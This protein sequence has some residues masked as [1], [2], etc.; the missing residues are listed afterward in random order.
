MRRRKDHRCRTAA[1]TER[2]GS[3]FSTGGTPFGGGGGVAA[4]Q[5]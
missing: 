4:A 3:L 5:N 2:N 1:E